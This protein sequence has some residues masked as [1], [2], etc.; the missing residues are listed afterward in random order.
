MVLVVV[1]GDHRVNEIKLQ[2][3][4]GEPFR[5]G[6]RRRG[7]AAHRPAGLHRAG[8]RRAAGAARRRGAGRR[9][10]AYV[11]GAN[12]PDAHLR[13]VEPGRDFAYESVDVR[14]R[15]GRATRSTAAR[16]GSSRRSRSATSSSS[17]PATRSRWAPRTWTRAGSR[18]ADLDGLLRLRPGAHRRRGGRAVRRRAR[19][20]A[21]R[22]RSRRSTSSWSRWASPA[23]EERAFAERLYGEL[24]ATGLDVLY[25]DRD[26]GPGEKF[27][28]AELLGCPLRL[29]VGRRTLARRGDRGAGAARPRVAH[30]P[31]GGRGG[32][33]GRA[34]AGAA[35][36]DAARVAPPGRASA[37]L[38][39]KRRLFGIDRSGPPPPRRRARTSP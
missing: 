15:R 24:E 4:L 20:L 33:G 16:S 8:R 9:R 27:A 22:A 28:D 31:A 32:G 11:A 37:R 19:D 23:R 7:R 10:R 6:A 29:T 1:R 34:V 25:D 17:A 21:G 35:V 14:T 12:E 30:G 26:A 13:G 2:N 18:A 38:I 36:S 5:A 3:A 39:T